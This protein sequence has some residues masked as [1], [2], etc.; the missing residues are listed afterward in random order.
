MRPTEW[1][2]W[3]GEGRVFCRRRTVEEKNRE[4]GPVRSIHRGKHNAT[5]VYVRGLEP[6]KKAPGNKLLDRAR[7]PMISSI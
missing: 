1:V 3:G 5:E 6:K 7:T 4:F 2:E